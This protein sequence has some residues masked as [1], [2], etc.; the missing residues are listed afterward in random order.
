[1]SF[2]TFFSCPLNLVTSI[3]FISYIYYQYF[4]CFGC[5]YGHFKI[6]SNSFSLMQPDYYNDYFENCK[7]SSLLFLNN[8]N[9]EIIVF[10][11]LWNNQK[12]VNVRPTSMKSPPPS[13]SQFKDMRRPTPAYGRYHSPILNVTAQMATRQGIFA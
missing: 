3:F 1:M 9:G 4:G 8:T 10:L 5:L 12:W 6:T 13:V 7:Q 2:S 11:D